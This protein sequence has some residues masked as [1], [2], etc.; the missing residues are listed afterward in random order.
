MEDLFQVTPAVAVSVEPQDE[1]ARLVDELLA[2][3]LAVLVL[4]EIAEICAG[5]CRVGLLDCFELGRTETSVAVLIG[6]LEH[7]L[8]KALPFVA[9]VD[10]IMIFVPG[11]RPVVEHG[12]WP[13]S[14]LGKRESSAC[15]KQSHR[16][17]DPKNGPKNGFSV[18]QICLLSLQPMATNARSG[19]REAGTRL[20]RP[21]CVGRRRLPILDHPLQLVIGE[22]RWRQRSAIVFGY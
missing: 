21:R 22:A 1:R 6:R 10:A 18:I 7:P 16:N 17:A 9:G 19:A 14:G 15:Q 5:Q 8:H 13:G 4:V 20:H 3:D 2:R 12:I 11:W